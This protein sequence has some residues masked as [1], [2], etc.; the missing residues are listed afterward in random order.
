MVQRRKATPGQGR[1]ENGGPDAGFWSCY[2]PGMMRRGR[3]GALALAVGLFFSAG[4][5]GQGARHG[6]E[7]RRA[8]RP[9]EHGGA[10]AD[11]I[12]AILAEPALSHAEFG[13]SVTT[14]D[15]QALYG[16]NDGRLF[17]PA[18]NAKL[19]TT[20]AV[21]ALLPVDTLTWTTNVVAA[22]TV[23]AAGTLHGDLVILGCGD[24][25][26]SARHYPYEP[27]QGA[28]AAETEAAQPAPKPNPMEVLNLLAQQV[29]QAG[30]REVD[31]SVVGD[32]SF[33]LD[34]PY[35]TAWAW[36]DLQWP[37]GAPVSALTFNDNAVGLTITGN[38]DAFTP[39]QTV[40]TWD[41]AVEYYTLDNTM[42]M[43]AAGETAHPGLDRRPGNRLVRAFGTAPAQGLHAG[44]AIEDPAEFTAAAFE[45]ALRSR[46]VSVT[47]GPTSAHRFS[48]ATGE[49]AAERSMPIK[50]LEPA[51]LATVE[52]PLEGR[53]VLAHRISVP[54]AEDIMMT[55]KNS[56]NL[57]AE[58]LLRLL[59]KTLGS[60][61]SFEEGTRVVRQF[62][63]NA[64]V[65]DNDFYF[66]DG[67]GMSMDDRIAPR[68]IT[69]LLAYAARQQWGQAWRESLPIA[70]V[71]GTLSGRFKN[72]PLKGRMWAKTG[73]L[74]ES[75]ALSGYMTTGSGKTLA[76]SIMVNG[77]RPGSNAELEAIDRIADAIAAAE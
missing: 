27:P 4:L 65:D 41:P 56:Q 34:E 3:W 64:G 46:G 57:H 7:S 69:K 38:P 19:L 25:T 75:S 63:V 43:A 6:E 1:M 26:L 50:P 18:S 62:M 28:P 30:V 77:H 47:G 8:A 74:N 66:Y 16:F 76:F 55:N 36:D 15:G 52:A 24:P 39:G 32:D 53:Q 2:T 29:V 73:T 48:I 60:D 67:S 5:Q 59:G 33:F 22:G 35:G 68:A 37:Y 17:V 20:A 31:G 45:V 23:D 11:R 21:A 61:G 10:L 72:S 51:T 54:V 71:D 13:I 49:F 9:A 44:L 14:L 42:T 12:N 70:G 58:L 40:G